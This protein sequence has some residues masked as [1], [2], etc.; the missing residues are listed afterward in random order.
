MICGIFMGL[1]HQQIMGVSLDIMGIIG[2]LL[3]YIYIYIH[4]TY[5]NYNL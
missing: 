4:I 5:G 1:N 2:Q 3:G